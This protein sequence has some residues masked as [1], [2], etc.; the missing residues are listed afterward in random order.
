MKINKLS[1]ILV[2]LISFGYGAYNTLP[3]KH[4]AYESIA[5][6]QILGYFEDFCYGSRPYKRLAIAK[7]LIRIKQ[8]NLTQKLPNEYYQ[9]LDEFSAD[10][11]SIEKKKDYLFA[12]INGIVDYNLK[13]KVDNQK[14]RPALYFDFA[15]YFGLKMSFI[16]DQ[17]LDNDPLYKGRT[18]S[19]F[20]GF[21]DQMYIAFAMKKLAIQFGRDYVDWGYGEVGNL[22]VSDNSR[23]FDMLHIKTKSSRFGFDGIIAQLDQIDEN[24][25]YLTATRFEYK[26]PVNVVIGFGH[27]ALYGGENQTINLAFS[28]PVSFS[29][30]EQ[31]N[32]SS[33]LNS[34]IYADIAWFFRN[35]Y[36]FFGELLIDDYQAEDKVQGDQEPNEIG[37]TLGCKFLNTFGFDGFVE[38]TQ[39]RNRTYNVSDEHQYEKYIHRNYVI[40][41]T[42][43]N[44]FR[45]LKIESEKW[46]NKK[47]QLGGGYQFLQKGEGTVLGTFTTPWMEID[48]KYS[49]DMPYGIVETTNTLYLTMLYHQACW[50]QLYA[51]LGYEF[52]N[53]YENIDG[54][55]KTGIIGSITIDLNARK[56]F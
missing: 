13:E 4:W 6:L 49:E 54:K 24:N 26:S 21:Q 48:G 47:L 30:A 7:E 18:Y 3:T 51:T 31:H 15:N 52:I 53:N 28:N 22:L 5:K 33:G 20:G 16:V 14:I 19:D 50:G 25:R 9:L 43:G 41:H 38:F 39:I 2:L 11:S 44:D 42:L 12:E 36:Q 45:M 55:S 32:N 40:G 29:Y 37:F 8:I 56:W 35:K 27:A 23:A 46:L 1:V 17:Q 34:M 10:I